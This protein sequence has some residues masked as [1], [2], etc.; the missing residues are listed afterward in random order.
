MQLDDASERDKHRLID[1]INLSTIIDL[2]SRYV[3]FLTYKKQRTDI[4][5]HGTPIGD[6]KT[7]KLCTVDLFGRW[8]C[9]R[10]YRSATSPGLTRSTT[11]FY[12]S[13]R[14]RL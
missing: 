6:T 7:S 13:H 5:Q 10:D 1:D 4:Q 2:R 9:S 11:T 14:T 3:S 8:H 12:Q